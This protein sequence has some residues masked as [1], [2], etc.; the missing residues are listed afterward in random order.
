MPMA[1][2]MR[3]E[4][5][6]MKPRVSVL[7]ALKTRPNDDEFAPAEFIGQ[8]AADHLPEKTGNGETA[9]H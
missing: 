4:K 7:R 5:L 8:R 3:A 1:S 9:Q 2:G 6:L